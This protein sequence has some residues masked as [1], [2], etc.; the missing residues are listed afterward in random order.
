MRYSLIALGAGNMAVAMFTNTTDS[1]A[2]DT[3]AVNAM[4]AT[5]GDYELVGCATSATKFVDFVNVATTE[6]MDVNFCG[7][8]CQTKFMAVDGK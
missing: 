8:S 4:P 2:A 1:Q 7:A 5:V 3:A 6:D